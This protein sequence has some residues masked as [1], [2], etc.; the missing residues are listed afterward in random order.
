[1]SDAELER[2]RAYL[3]AIARFDKEWSAGGEL[4][5]VPRAQYDALMGAAKYVFDGH[6]HDASCGCYTCSV[7]AALRAAGIDPEE[8]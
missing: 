2:D 8:K 1:M 7:C 5:F 6:D 4:V 3:A